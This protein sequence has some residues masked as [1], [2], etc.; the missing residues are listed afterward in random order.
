MPPAVRWVDAVA[1]IEA[2]KT[3]VALLTATV[4]AL[5]PVAAA[6]LPSSPPL[7]LLPPFVR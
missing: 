7:P 2:L 1:Q 6:K 4:N 5:I 3:Q